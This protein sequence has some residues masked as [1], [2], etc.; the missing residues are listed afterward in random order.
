MALLE[1]LIVTAC[2][3]TGKGGQ[4]NQEACQKADQAAAAQFVFIQDT[5]KRED[6]NLKMMEKQANDDVGIR[7]VQ[8]IG[9]IVFVTKTLVSKSLTVGLPNMGICDSLKA[10]ANQDQSLLKMEWKW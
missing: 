9:G 8:V 2:L 5:N 4:A 10:E 6:Q 3:A 7:Q 1:N